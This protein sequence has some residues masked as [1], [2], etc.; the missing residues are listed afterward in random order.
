MPKEKDGTPLKEMLV[1][2]SPSRFYLPSAVQSKSIP[3]CSQASPAP[4]PITNF[5]I[6]LEKEIPRNTKFGGI[7]HSILP[8]L[9]SYVF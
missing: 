8:P 5:L 7:L 4:P 6:I 1:T 3:L 2:F 9:K